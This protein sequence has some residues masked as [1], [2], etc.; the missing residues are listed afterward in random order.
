MHAINRLQGQ[1]E[2][3]V[4]QRQ[5]TLDLFESEVWHQI[6]AEVTAEKQEATQA[7]EQR[8]EDARKAQM[9]L[10][11]EIEAM[12]TTIREEYEP[13]FGKDLL[14]RSKLDSL[15]QFCEEHAD[16]SVEEA[17]GQYRSR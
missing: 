12:E 14:H 9:T 5:A 2:E 6:T 16:L 3:T 8:L 7:V 17:V 10:D 13:L 1:M 15:S 11:N 4:N